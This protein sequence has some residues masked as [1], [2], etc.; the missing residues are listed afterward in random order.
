MRKLA[1]AALLLSMS[2]ASGKYANVKTEKT[3]PQYKGGT[4]KKTLVL[5]AIPDRI[6][7]ENLEDQFAIEGVERGI[8]LNPSYRL[9]ANFKDVTKEAL[10]NLVKTEGFDRVLIIKSVK[11]SRKT[12]ENSYYGDY[13]SVVGSGIMPGMYDYWGGTVVTVYSPT[14]P[15]PSLLMF[16][17]VMVESALYDS[18]DASI[19]WSA[20]T[21][22]TS[23]RDRVDAPKSYVSTIVGLLQNKKLL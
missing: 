7:R 17:Q 19:V 20:V 11:G 13:Y 3:N 14:D 23:S 21:E 15:P 16:T 6:G 9:I 1:I 2:C 10:E 12:G 22:L 4:A 8:S 5:V 18:S